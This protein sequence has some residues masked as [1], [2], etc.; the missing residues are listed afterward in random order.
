MEETDDRNYFGQHVR[1]LWM[2][3]T[4][5]K[6]EGARYGS[7]VAAVLN[8]DDSLAPPRLRRC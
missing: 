3:T 8:S 4:S 1:L 7:Y 2:E 6:E 5:R